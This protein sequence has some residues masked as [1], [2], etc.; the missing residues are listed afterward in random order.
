[1]TTTVNGALTF[2]PV[3]AATLTAPLA[4]Y[5][6]T[7]SEAGGAT[8]PAPIAVATDVTSFTVALD[9]GVWTASVVAV[10]TDGNALSAPVVSDALTIAAPVVATVNIP[11]AISLTPAV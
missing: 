6:V 9:A 2:V 5:L 8:A 4:G 11:S 3:D 1:M 7:L 10:D